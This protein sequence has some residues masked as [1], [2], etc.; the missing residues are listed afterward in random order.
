VTVTSGSPL[1]NIVAVDPIVEAEFPPSMGSYVSLVHNGNF[2]L[3]NA[4]GWTVFGAA[5]ATQ[6]TD[7]VIKH[8]GSYSLKVVGTINT[9]NVAVG[10]KINI[11]PG[12]R[13]L[14]RG[15][16][17]TDAV[18][19]GYCLLLVKFFSQSDVQIGVNSEFA[20][21]SGTTDWT[22][23]GG[24]KTAP[25]GTYYA[26]LDCYFFNFVGTGYFDDI[27]AWVI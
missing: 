5:G 20:Q 21:F 18:T 17:K 14:A 13:L 19:N 16:C 6:T 9:S 8:S 12:Q 1:I 10:Q 24:C 3:G 15:Y 2:E 25:A 4:N 11:R 23:T 22:L 26:R 27:G 7:N